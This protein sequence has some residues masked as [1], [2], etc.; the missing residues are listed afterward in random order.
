MEKLSR[1]K[2]GLDVPWVTSWSGE[3][4]LG[5]RPCPSL[6][7]GLA[8]VQANLPGQGRPNYSQNHLVRQ[9]WSIRK[10]LCPMCGKPT[11]E[12]DRWTQT[13]RIVTAGALRQKGLAALLPATLDDEQTVL[14]AGAISP[15]H[16]VCMDLS[17]ARCPHLQ[18]HAS[19]EPIRFPR[20]W[21]VLP[22]TI[23]ARPP[24]AHVL[25]MRA[26]PGAAVAVTSFLQLLGLPEAA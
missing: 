1:L 2:V 10:M 14:D 21:T 5:V 23:E 22:L 7:G 6:D 15:A 13:G 20:R 16:R 4:L 18:A 17:L 19:P 12:D 25:E 8:V 24:Q 26:R 3:S 11:P 9:R